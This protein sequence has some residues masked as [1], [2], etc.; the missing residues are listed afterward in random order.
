MRATD[1]EHTGAWRYDFA[2]HPCNVLLVGEDNPQS[3][4]PRH[5]LYPY[6]VHCAGHRFAEDI[7]NVGMG[8]QLATWRTNLCAGPWRAAE[9]RDRARALVVSDGVPWRVIIMFG[10]KVAD[11]FRYVNPTTNIPTT[12]TYAPFSVTRVVHRIQE[13]SSPTRA[14]IDWI[15][16][17]QL[18]HP[19]GRNRVWNDAAL[20]HRA[21]ALLASVAP[22]WYGECN[23]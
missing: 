18:P 10:A 4:D 21:R 5:A 20:I 9:A 2:E 23:I 19:S 16:L 11:A 8:H 13:A 17:V 15:H 12:G 7:A 3:S 14:N 22:A 1:I 6:P